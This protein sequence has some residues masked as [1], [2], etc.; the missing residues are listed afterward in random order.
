MPKK[1]IK[2]LPSPVG[3]RFFLKRRKDLSGISGTGMVAL[4]IQMPSGKVVIEWLGDMPSETIFSNLEEMLKIHGHDGAT[5]IE[6]IDNLEL[7]FNFKD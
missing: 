6:W 3:K 1:K 4:G 2:I 5:T 7:T